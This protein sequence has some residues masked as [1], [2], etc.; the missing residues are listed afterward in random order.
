MKII[1]YPVCCIS[2]AKSLVVDNGLVNRNK[3]QLSNT[4][5]EKKTI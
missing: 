5:Q 2:S 4:D 3:G 1:H